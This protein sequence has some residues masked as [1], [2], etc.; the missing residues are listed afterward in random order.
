MQDNIVIGDLKRNAKQNLRKGLG[1][2]YLMLMVKAFI[3]SIFTSITGTFIFSISS[4]SIFS[5]FESIADE[6]Y[7]I[8]ERDLANLV[9]YILGHI[10]INAVLQILR[11]III[12]VATI[13]LFNHLQVGI[14]LWFSRNREGRSTPPFSFLFYQFS[15]GRYFPTM[16]GIAWRDLWLFF[17]RLPIIITSYIYFYYSMDFVKKIIEFL[18]PQIYRRNLSK[19]I[20]ENFSSEVNGFIGLSIAYFSVLIVFGIITIIKKYSY[21]AT[22][23]ILADN[24][25]LDHK[26]ALDLSKKMVKG[27]RFKWFLL[28]LSFV[29][30]YILLII[31]FIFSFFLSPLLNSYIK[32]SHAEFYAMLRKRAVKN[33]LI[34]MEEL[35]YVEF[36]SSQN[37]T[38]RTATD[39]YENQNNL[40]NQ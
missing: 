6:I 5:F 17:W 30:W 23:W 36:V 1:T 15:D 35:G 2:S 7:A 28:D 22:E 25:H 12:V 13:L 10:N 20:L 3:M 21:R 18:Y 19:I 27:Y 34:S 8:S 16:K 33:D 4:S 37:Q 32:A 26:V 38:Y 29:G 11:Q 31:L 9:L 24:P 14:N 40:I 39:F